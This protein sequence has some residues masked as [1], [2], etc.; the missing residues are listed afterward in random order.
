VI[1]RHFFSV[2]GYSVERYRLRAISACRDHHSE[3]TVLNQLRARSAEPRGEQAISGR[4]RA[5][6]LYVAEDTDTTFQPGPFLQFA[7][8]AKRVPGVMLIQ[9]S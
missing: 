1:E 3:D 8:E 5:T 7:R 6:P 2:A 9:I 4:W